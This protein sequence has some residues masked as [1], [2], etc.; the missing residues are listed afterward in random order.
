MAVALSK[1]NLTIET[2]CVSAFYQNCRLIVAPDNVSALL[3]D[4]GA[5]A[6]RI[7]SRIRERGLTLKEIWLTHAHLDH[8]GAVREIVLETDA[9]LL[10]HPAEKQLRA[11]VQKIA[12]AYGVDDGS[13]QDC[14]EPNRLLSGGEKLSFGGVEFDVLFTP[15]H[16]PGHLCFFAPAERLLLCGDTIFAGA[17]GRTDLPGGDYATLMA[18]IKMIVQ[19]VPVE[20]ALLP[21]HGEDTTLAEELKT[22]PFLVNLR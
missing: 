14:P 4:P 5:E 11:N 2:L 3:I 17:I 9:L 6:Q 15:G 19:S 10:G 22:N 1:K 13:Y 8:C 12:S 7:L 16:S 18:S 20:T 21:G